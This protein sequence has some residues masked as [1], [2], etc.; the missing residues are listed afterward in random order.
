[1][2]QVF[3]K[4]RRDRRRA[5]SLPPEI[6]RLAWGSFATQVGDG[7][8][9]TCW[10]VFFTRVL[11]FR[12]GTVGVVMTVAG[13]AALAGAAPLGRLADRVGPRGLFVALLVIGGVAMSA[14]TLVHSVWAFAAVACVE[15]A[16]N[17]GRG[18]VRDALVTGLARQRDERLAALA[19]MRALGQTGAG[20][21]AAAGALVL[22]SGSRTLFVVL[23]L[24][25]AGSFLAYAAVVASLP[26]VPAAESTGPR[27]SWAVLRDGPFLGLVAVSSVLT[28][29]WGMLSAG[30]PLWI[31]GHTRAPA[32]LAGVVVLASSFA[33][34]LFQQR[35]SAAGRSLRRSARAASWSAAALAATCALWAAAAG[36]GPRLAMALLGAGAVLHILGELLFVS[37]SWGFVVALMPEH[38][39]GEYQGAASTGTAAAIMAGPVVMLALV[40]PHG[41]AGWLGLAAAFLAAGLAAYPLARAGGRRTAPPGGRD[42]LERSVPRPLVS[43]D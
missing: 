16:A 27:R 4:R 30:L 28:L 14:F 18:G 21:G 5:R 13:A 20:F 17:K 26:A 9:F 42:T 40:V 32:A 39:R 8:W 37:A 15:T 19:R 33:I 23:I 1:M 36:R 7:A 38:A 25:N 3:V 24:A 35:F 22:T 11:G 29:C 43:R 6:R 10:A 12:A 34:G 41:T 2:I 31:T